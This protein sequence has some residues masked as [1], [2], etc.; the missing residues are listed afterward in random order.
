M[1]VPKSASNFSSADQGAIDAAAQFAAEQNA[2]LLSGATNDGTG[3]PT[4]AED[5][6]PAGDNLVQS[7]LLTCTAQHEH[8]LDMQ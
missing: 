2:A 4:N 8:N 3:G 1:D 5:V 6:D 7:E